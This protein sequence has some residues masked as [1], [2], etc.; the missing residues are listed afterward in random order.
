MT[1][2]EHTKEPLPE[3][4]Y[5]CVNLKVKQRYIN[6]LVITPGSAV[7][8]TSSTTVSTVKAVRLFDISDKA[9][10]IIEDFK[11]YND[12]PYGCVKLV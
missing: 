9:H 7:I 12:S 2:I 1:K 6:P 8:S 3:N 4:E 5:F 10:R 11:A